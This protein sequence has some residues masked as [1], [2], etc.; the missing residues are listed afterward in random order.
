M[1]FHTYSLHQLGWQPRFARR[2]T[3]A[4]FEA[5]HPARVVAVHRHELTVLSSQGRA[6][7]ALPLRVAGA[8]SP[9]VVGDWV[10]LG[11]ATGRVQR[12]LER[13][14]LVVM[15]G[16]PVVANLDTLFVIADGQHPYERSLASALALAREARVRPVLV[17][18]GSGADVDARI[19]AA[20]RL[21]P[22]LV[23]AAVDRAAADPLHALAS[24]LEPG[25]TVAFIGMPDACARLSRHRLDGHGRRETR[26]IA[27]ADGLW[28]TAS[29]AWVVDVRELHPATTGRDMV[30]TP[31]S[32]PVRNPPPLRALAGLQ[33]GQPSG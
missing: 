2:L 15:G 3:L 23:V 21:R 28:A 8:H 13:R 10:L 12:L 25:R 14:S 31:L 11:H 33:P 9:V 4:D 26:G 5:G 16:R 32:R 22:G 1:P 29:G 24:G 18:M 20:R 6:T 27:V 17:P 19:A 7:A 30:A